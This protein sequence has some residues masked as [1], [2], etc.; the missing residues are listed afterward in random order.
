ME[1]EGEPYRRAASSERRASTAGAVSV[2]EYGGEG[3]ELSLGFRERITE[4]SIGLLMGFDFYSQS[5]KLRPPMNHSV[6]YR[7]RIT[8]IILSH[9]IKKSWSFKLHKCPLLDYSFT[10]TGL[11]RHRKFMKQSLVLNGEHDQIKRSLGD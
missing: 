9:L 3:M 11:I 10:D 4:G 8:E 5:R 2:R 1:G 7:V 6:I